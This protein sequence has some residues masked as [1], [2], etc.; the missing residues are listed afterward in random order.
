[1]PGR[2]RSAAWG[3]EAEANERGE[4]LIWLEATVVDRLAGRRR[5][6]AKSFSGWSRRRRLREAIMAEKPRFNGI[7][8]LNPRSRRLKIANVTVLKTAEG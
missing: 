2:F 6:T 8:R 3:Y 7:V 4:R 1:M 5:V